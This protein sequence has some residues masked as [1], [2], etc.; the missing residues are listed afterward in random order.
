MKKTA[1]LSISTILLVLLILLFIPVTHA[2]SDACNYL[3]TGTEDYTGPHTGELNDGINYWNIGDV[4]TGNLLDGEALTFTLEIL[5]GDFDPFNFGMQLILVD[6]S[7]DPVGFYDFDSYVSG[8]VW[9]STGI[10][11]YDGS[12]WILAQRSIP[13]LE[14]TY[15][16]EVRCNAENQTPPPTTD[17][18]QISSPIA[19]YENES[20]SINIACGEQEDNVYG[21]EF[22]HSIDVLSPEIIPQSTVYDEGSIFI[23]KDSYTLINTLIDG[24]A[25][26]LLSPELPTTIVGSETLGSVT[27][28]TDLPGTVIFNLDN[29]ILGN[30]SADQIN[31][32]VITQTKVEIINLDLAAVSGTAT[33]ETGLDT[34][35]D[36]TLTIDS[37]APIST[38]VANGVYDFEYDETVALDGTLEADAP[39]HLYCTQQ[40]AL[41]DEIQN[42]L[43]LIT[44]LAGDVNDD[45]EINITDGSV[46]VS[47]RIGDTVPEGSTPDLNEDGI[48]NIL[49]IIHVGRNFGEQHPNTCFN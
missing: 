6:Q 42:D 34:G 16:I 11:P 24:Y 3:N 46:I 29:L 32:T 22:A 17:I 18:C 37:I 47:A 33:R 49:D 15:T 30:E 21:F 35:A 23:S 14:M 44:L 25:L 48:I 7:L 41:V 13:T 10:V 1:F 45:D 39:G 20:F 27:Y 12:F 5:T 9:T 40:L 26:S 36:I 28:D 43:P 4:H 8:N 2:Q 31:A 19:V 38:T